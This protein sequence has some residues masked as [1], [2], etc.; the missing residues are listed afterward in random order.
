MSDPDAGLA[1]TRTWTRLHSYHSQECP[2]HPRPLLPR[3]QAENQ[4]GAIVRLPDRVLEPLLQGERSRGG[5]RRWDGPGTGVRD[6]AA[7]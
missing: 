6:R 7:A 4:S 2:W 1:L 5:I 3:P